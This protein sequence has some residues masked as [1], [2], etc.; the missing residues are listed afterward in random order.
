[1]NCGQVDQPEGGLWPDDNVMTEPTTDTENY[2]KIPMYTDL[3]QEFK[4]ALV[5][6]AASIIPVHPSVDPNNGW[7]EEMFVRTLRQIARDVL[8]KHKIT[9]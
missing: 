2:S 7:V 6:V 5:D 8:D 1:M 9:Y 4:D 3:E